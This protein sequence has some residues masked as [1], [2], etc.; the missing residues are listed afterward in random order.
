MNGK[1]FRQYQ[2]YT[3]KSKSSSYSFLSATQFSSGEAATI[4]SFFC[5]L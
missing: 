2:M 5:I 1:N 3:V 4:T